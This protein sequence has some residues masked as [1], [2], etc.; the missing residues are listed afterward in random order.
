MYSPL[1]TVMPVASRMAKNDK[2]VCGILS[3]KLLY[4]TADDSREKMKLKMFFYNSV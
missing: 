2:C 3:T 1:M 4:S